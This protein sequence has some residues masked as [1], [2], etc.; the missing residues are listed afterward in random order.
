[1][2]VKGLDTDALMSEF[3]AGFRV[4]MQNLKHEVEQEWIKQAEASLTESKDEYLSGLEF[5]VS[6]EKI[7]V[8]VTG[9]LPVAIEQGSAPWD[10]KPGLLGPYLKRVIY[11]ERFTV[12]HTKFKTVSINS[13][14]SSWWHPGFASKSIGPKV[15]EA[16]NQSLIEK[17]FG[18]VFS[19]KVKF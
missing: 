9:K 17:A 5:N 8:T 18:P 10:M 19:S 1:M 4:G 15:Q 12:P 13:P 11:S 2:V 7:E 14:A 16:V 3:E 6:G